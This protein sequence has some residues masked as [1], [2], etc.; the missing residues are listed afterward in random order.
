M[1]EDAAK[2]GWMRLAARYRDKARS[3]PEHAA[4]FDGVA[5]RFEATARGENRSKGLTQMMGEA[6][7]S[8]ETAG[9]AEPG[10]GKRPA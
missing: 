3:F 7:H 2:G 5:E 9:Q 8:A 1:M 4:Y 10:D 6:W